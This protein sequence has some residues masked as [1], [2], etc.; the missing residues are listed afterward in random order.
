MEGNYWTRSLGARLSRRRALVATGAGALGAAFLAACGGNDGSDNSA[1]DANS[2]SED[3]YG[4]TGA[5]G[6]DLTDNGV[7]DGANGLADTNAAAPADHQ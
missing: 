3:P 6:A 2:I 1:G 7:T 5:P 4:A